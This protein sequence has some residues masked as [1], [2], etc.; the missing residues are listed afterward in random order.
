MSWSE[1]G[2]QVGC[3]CWVGGFTHVYLKSTGM[4]VCVC[5]IYR[6]SRVIVHFWVIAFCVVSNV[7]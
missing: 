7:K 6:I 1:F 4:C 5:F 3:A 2:V